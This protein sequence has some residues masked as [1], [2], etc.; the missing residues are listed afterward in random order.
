[1]SNGREPIGKLIKIVSQIFETY[2]NN[3]LKDINLTSSQITILMYIC[4][5]YKHNIDINQVNIQDR[6]NLS[7]PTVTGILNRLADK[8]FIT[9]IRDGRSN[10]IIPTDVSLSILKDGQRQVGQIEDKILCGLTSSEIANLSDLLL[11]IINNN[12]IGVG[13]ND[14][15]II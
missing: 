14:K 7:N 13:L 3:S 15:K 2:L 12:K 6:F 5:N 4:Y 9:R 10:K 1:M 11:K 8:K